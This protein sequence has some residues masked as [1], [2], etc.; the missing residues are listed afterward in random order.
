MDENYEMVE[1]SNKYLTL[2]GRLMTLSQSWEQIGYKRGF[3]LGVLVGEKS[4]LLM[5]LERRFGKAIDPYRS[6]VEQAPSDAIIAWASL[7]IDDCLL[8]DIFPS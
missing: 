6:L 1:T 7:L 8:E 5:Q 4:I 2:R 3:S